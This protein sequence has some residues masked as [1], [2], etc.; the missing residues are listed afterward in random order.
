MKSLI[1]SYNTCHRSLVARH[2]Q[3]PHTLS[4]RAETLL[5]RSP[6]DLK[7]VGLDANQ[8][9]VAYTLGVFAP[10]WK[11]WSSLRWYSNPFVLP[12]GSWPD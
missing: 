12:F 7:D 2:L 9:R 4:V 11:S 5:D 10:V 6:P 8:T 3:A 1:H